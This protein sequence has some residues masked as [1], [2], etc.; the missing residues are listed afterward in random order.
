MDLQ[1]VM[2][3]TALAKPHAV[4]RLAQEFPALVRALDK[5]G[6]AVLDYYTPPDTKQPVVEVTRRGVILEI[7]RSCITPHV[8]RTLTRDSN[9]I[10]RDPVPR[11]KTPK[12]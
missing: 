5:H 9:P 4:L 12:K 8:L 11:P 10:W 3:A 2:N 6:L 1:D 7:E